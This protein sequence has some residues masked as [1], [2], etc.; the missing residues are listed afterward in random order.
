MTSLFSTSTRRSRRGSNG[1]IEKVV[2]A[3][4]Y[5]RKRGTHVLDIQNDTHTPANRFAPRAGA[6]AGAASRFTLP[7]TR[8]KGRCRFKTEQW[9]QHPL[10]ASTLVGLCAIVL[11]V[12]LGTIISK[13]YEPSWSVLEAVYFTVVSITTVGYGDFSPTFWSHRVI[14]SLYLLFGVGFVGVVRRLRQLLA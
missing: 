5:A 9:L 10:N 12:A 11:Y 2:A 6:A 7:T 4:A 1:D 8:P 13:V 3:A 14:N